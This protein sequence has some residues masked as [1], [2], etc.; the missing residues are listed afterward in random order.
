M[1]SLYGLM[2]AKSWLWNLVAEDFS[3]S[4]VSSLLSYHHFAAAVAAAG[5]WLS[6][7]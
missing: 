3:I 7:S 4:L 5:T 6:Y 2:E 1:A